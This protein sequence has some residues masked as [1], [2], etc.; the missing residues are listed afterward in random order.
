MW[1][2]KPK[3]KKLRQGLAFINGIRFVSPSQSSSVVERQNRIKMAELCPFKAG[4]KV[5][6]WPILGQ[7]LAVLAIFFE[8]WTSN[9]ICL[10]FP[11]ISRGQPSWKLIGPKLTVFASK[12]RKN[13]HISKSHFAQVS[14]TKKLTPPRFF[15]NLSETFR[16][17]VNMADFNLGPQKV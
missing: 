16:I 5:A 6:S 2:K 4:E 12:N 13:G 7:K 11:M 17:V 3:S 1:T 9:L 10:S 8:I 14:I 15:I